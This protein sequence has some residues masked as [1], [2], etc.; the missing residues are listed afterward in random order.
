L[1]AAGLQILSQ[2]FPDLFS[3]GPSGLPL[4]D[5]IHTQRGKHP[6]YC[7]VL[8]ICRQIVTQQGH[9]TLAEDDGGEGGGDPGDDTARE[10]LY[11]QEFTEFMHNGNTL[12]AMGR[13]P[14][15]REAGTSDAFLGWLRSI[16]DYN[17]SA[18][19]SQQATAISEEANRLGLNVRLDPGTLRRFLGTS[20]I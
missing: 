14:A 19:T 4:Y 15:V 20:Y 5:V 7:E 8:G 10:G 11:T 2:F 17:G 1:V 6:A 18:V 16:Q 12:D 9:V 13:P 3:G